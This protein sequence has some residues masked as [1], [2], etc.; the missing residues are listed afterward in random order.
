MK[1]FIGIWEIHSPFTIEPRQFLATIRI[2]KGWRTFAFL[3]CT[4][5]YWGR[6]EVSDSITYSTH[7]LWGKESIHDENCVTR[8]GLYQPASTMTG[9]EER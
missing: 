7:T 2:K 4:G 5:C 9:T 3:V 1:A 8:K 6:I